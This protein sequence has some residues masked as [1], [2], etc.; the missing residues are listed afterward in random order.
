MKIRTKFWII[1]VSFWA[2][3]VM[4]SGLF[5]RIGGEFFRAFS[6]ADGMGHAE[7]TFMILGT[8]FAFSLLM[9]IAIGL[10][11]IPRSFLL[12]NRLFPDQPEEANKIS[13]SITIFGAG[14]FAL[15]AVAMIITTFI[16]I[17]N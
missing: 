17:C 14:I 4:A 13:K 5:S 15:I 3:L 6:I 9:L 1:E 12:W 2:C 8:C 11:A 10:I 16:M 7:N